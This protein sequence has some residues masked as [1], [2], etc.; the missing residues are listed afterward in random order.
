MIFLL[1][2]RRPHRSKRT[3][4]LYPYT[5]LF[6]CAEGGAVAVDGEQVGADLEGQ[7]ER[8]GE[9]VEAFARPCVD[10]GRD[11]AQPHRCPQQRAGLERVQ[12]F[13]LLDAQWRHGARRID[14]QRSEEHTSELQ[15]L[16]RISYA[17]FCLKKKT[18]NTITT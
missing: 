2:I 8:V 3:D 14:V 15:S 18:H 16:M 5:T 13:E 12:A 1:K 4:T 11:R 6:R 9:A 7:A 17:V 10:A